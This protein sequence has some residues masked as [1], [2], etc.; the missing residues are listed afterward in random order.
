[1]RYAVR[2][3]ASARPATATAA[4]ARIV[5]MVLKIGKAEVWSMGRC[6]VVAA[7]GAITPFA[8]RTVGHIGTL[9]MR[10]AWGGAKLCRIRGDHAREVATREFARCKDR[11]SVEER[12]IKERK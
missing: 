6:P 7:V 5:L 4:A 10:R 3:T 9:S 11:D 12:K 1:M 8:L 2:S